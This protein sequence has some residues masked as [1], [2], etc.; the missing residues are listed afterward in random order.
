MA[1]LSESSG[2]SATNGYLAV[3]G[4]GEGGLVNLGTAL[5]GDRVQIVGDDLLALL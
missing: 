4:R 1:L 2:G 5:V 3:V